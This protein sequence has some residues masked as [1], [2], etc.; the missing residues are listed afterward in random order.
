MI[1]AIFLIN[2]QSHKMHLLYINFRYWLEAAALW[3][4]IAAKSGACCKRLQASA[5]AGLQSSGDETCH[6]A[7][8]YGG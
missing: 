1:Y 7:L 3:L 5:L 8:K 6:L 4:C 2:T